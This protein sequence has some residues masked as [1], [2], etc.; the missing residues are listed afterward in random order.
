MS[1]STY[2]EK[3]AVEAA[4]KALRTLHAGREQNLWLG[5]RE[6][7]PE[8]TS[9]NLAR[10][11]VERFR[12]LVEM[13]GI[14]GH[15]RYMLKPEVDVLPYL[16]A[17]ERLVD[18]LWTQPAPLTVPTQSLP[19]PETDEPEPSVTRPNAG[20]S[21]AVPPE[22]ENGEVEYDEIDLTMLRLLGALTENVA[23]LRERTI[24]LEE[25]LNECLNILKRL[26]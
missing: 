26:L 24:R 16:T 19:N 7:C 3:Q 10:F 25:G 8:G 23:V 22:E 18:L 21:L 4:K 15:S 17:Q 20:L 11:L 6:F 2:T 13:Q 12:D 1:K 14:K 5:R 9:T